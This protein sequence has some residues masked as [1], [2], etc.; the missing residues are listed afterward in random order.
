M[1]EKT[2]I[3]TARQVS[4]YLCIPLRTVQHLSKQGKIK[5]FKIGSRWRYLRT[6]I[7][8]YGPCYHTDKE[9]NFFTAKQTAEYFCI[10]LR[11]LYRYSKLG[12]IKAFKIGGQWRYLIKKPDDFIERRTCPRINTNLE[13]QYS[14]NLPP[15]KTINN[16]GIVK[17][18]STGGILFVS[19]DDG[20]EADDLISMNFM[21]IKIEGRVIRKDAGGFAVKFRNMKESSKNKIIQYVG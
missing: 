14:I 3:L 7:E 4:K 13:C 16:T 9:P 11:T 10:N 12:K 2:N 8:N 18:L 17:N 5:S 21:D 1:I 20:I 15:F 19:E 6:D